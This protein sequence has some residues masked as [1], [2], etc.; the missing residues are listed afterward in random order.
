MKISTRL[1]TDNLKSIPL[2]WVTFNW[3]NYC[4]H[5]V[6]DSCMLHMHPLLADDEYITESMRELCDYIREHYDMGEIV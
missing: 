5:G 4:K 2:L 1:F 3:Q 6:Q